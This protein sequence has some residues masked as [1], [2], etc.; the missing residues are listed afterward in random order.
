MSKK[1][2]IF[3]TILTLAETTVEGVGHIYERTMEGHFEE[4]AEIFTDV[5]DAFHEIRMALLAYLPAYRGSDLEKITSEVTEGMKLMLAAFEG[6]HDVRPMV[7]L[8]FSL[9]PGF[10]KWHIALQ[11]VLGVNCAA[12]MN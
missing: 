8:Q 6:E 2:D 10:K 5:A 12:A 11:E 3:K 4:T 9:V 1:V 7:V